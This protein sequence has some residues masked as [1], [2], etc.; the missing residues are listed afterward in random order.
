MNAQEAA[1]TWAGMD[2]LSERQLV[3]MLLPFVTARTN[4]QEAEKVMNAFSERI[5]AWLEAHYGYELLDGERR[6]RAYL[7]P[8]RGSKTVD[9]QGL[10]KSDPGLFE[11]LFELGCLTVNMK[12]VEAQGANIAGLSGWE[13]FAANTNALMVEVMKEIKDAR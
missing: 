1:E 5:K 9:L 13:S 10:R 11:R 6:I 12:A 4:K 8:R 2:E 3:E 7:Q